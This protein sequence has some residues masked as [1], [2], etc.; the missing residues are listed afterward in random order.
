MKKY[1]GIPELLEQ[2]MGEAGGDEQWITVQELR[3]RFSL[4]RYQCNTVSGFLRRLEYGS[5]GGFPY[6]VMRIEQVEKITP[7]DPPRRRYLV[8]KK[9]VPGAL[10]DSIASEHGKISKSAS[11]IR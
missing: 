3:N 7:S 4:T 2:F 1:H 5:F 10:P 11:Q 6:I 8:Q 9:Y